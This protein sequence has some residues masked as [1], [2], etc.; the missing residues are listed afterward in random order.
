MS[1]KDDI[2]RA[3]AEARQR[4][5]DETNPYVAALMDLAEALTDE[6]IR[7]EVSA[8]K[9]Q[10]WTLS[11]YPQHRPS[12]KTVL[13]SM[14][15]SD[16]KATVL[17]GERREF[18]TREALENYL[19]D[20]VQL[21]TFI[22][23]LSELEQEAKEPVGAYLRVLDP[24]TISRDD[25]MLVVTPD[26]QRHLSEA[27]EGAELDLELEAGS[28]I[29]AGTY[30]SSVPY[31][32]LNSAGVVLRIVETDRTA[33]GKIRVRGRRV[34]SAR[35]NGSIYDQLSN[36]DLSNIGMKLATGLR[37]LVSIYRRDKAKLDEA[38]DEAAR[39]KALHY[40]PDVESLKRYIRDQYAMRGV[41][42]RECKLDLVKR[43]RAGAPEEPPVDF[44]RPE[45]P[46]DI[47]RIA[48]F[49]ETA[50]RALAA[51]PAGASV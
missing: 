7:A 8:A 39:R 15:I 35:A 51:R 46:L 6:S 40:A 38:Q 12:S 4:V 17:T 25:F 20:F 11:V 48:D 47:E 49:L 44:Y 18:L 24:Q 13:M 41:Q 37:G 5:A 32:F 22:S 31:R 10:R 30:D 27:A 19:K 28:A 45:D 14:A 16:D 26:N 50:A 34:A 9:G 42:V 21:E 2:R 33:E 29:G 36:E 43:L 3:V 23:S 1:F